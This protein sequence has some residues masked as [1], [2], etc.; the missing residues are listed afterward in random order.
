MKVTIYQFCRGFDNVRYSDIYQ[1]Y[2]SGGY[3]FNQIASFN[4]KI[5]EPITK[6][7]I[8]GYFKL[9][10]NYPPEENDFALIAREIDDKYSV[11]AVAN[12]QLDDGGRP[13]IGYKYFWLEKS[14]PEVDGIGT[15]IHWWS[16]EQPQFDM[17]E[18]DET[19]EKSKSIP[20]F[21]YTQEQPKIN[22]AQNFAQILKIVENIHELPKIQVAKKVAWQEYEPYIETH[23]L[24]LAM[25]ERSHYYNAWAWNVKKL[26][27]PTSF[28]AIFYSSNE[29]IPHISKLPLTTKPN[30][31][32]SNLDSNTELTEDRE[33]IASR[34]KNLSQTA[35]IQK[36]KNCLTD[37][38]TTFNNHHRLDR[39]R[40]QDL[41]RYLREYP[42]INWADCINEK[43]LKNS[44]IDDMYPQLIYM[45]APEYPASQ[46][47]LVEMVNSVKMESK[48][49]SQLNQIFD[50]CREKA[51]S[52]LGI[53][54]LSENTNQESN[55]NI[56]WALLNDSQDNPEVNKKLQNS[57]FLGIKFLL[58]DL[59]N[60]KIDPQKVHYFLTKSG[61]IWHD[62]FQK[63]A[64]VFQKIMLT[65]INKM[66]HEDS[67]NQSSE[68]EKT[69]IENDDNE[70]V[71]EFCKPIL[72]IIKKII[73]DN[74][75]NP[76][77]HKTYGKYKNLAKV[78]HKIGK[79][80]VAKL[81]EDITENKITEHIGSE[82]KQRSKVEKNR[83]HN[84]DDDGWGIS[85]LLLII[86][87]LGVVL[88][89]I[90]I[91]LANNP[92]N[93]ISLSQKN[94]FFGIGIMSLII[95][96]ASAFLF[97]NKPLV[98]K[99][100]NIQ[101]YVQYLYIVLAVALLIIGLYIF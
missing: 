68:I 67:E 81:L 52:V 2:V 55:N 62:E 76:S 14:S 59:M 79:T 78:F 33:N 65:E 80:K 38:A 39:K 95:C 27:L 22:F 89:V 45:V 86:F 66:L 7:V 28:L 48:K 20:H 21:S 30:N 51:R 98:I 97:T 42:D 15:L 100:F 25:S 69:E 1:C 60:K 85:I 9:N 34:P 35:P 8:D 73:K 3:C 53:L 40:T 17:E 4:Q 93:N 29:D 50:E 83:T 90:F 32:E 96:T 58:E 101:K 63:Y 10:D 61:T 31:S 18:L 82:K 94:I 23:Y 56:Q 71:L 88:F 70:V 54:H 74:Q 24:A 47:W 92:N 36:I 6:A 99:D 77:E 44:A 26:Q 64:K 43:M 49:K 46:Q 11:L 72:N 57:I 91:H 13:T 12:R 84:N 5:P 75:D 19:S 87:I 41:F 16:K 37:I